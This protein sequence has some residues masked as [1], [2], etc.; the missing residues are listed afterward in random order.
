MEVVGCFLD[1]WLHM[2][3][4]KRMRDK[5]SSSQ[6]TDEPAQWIVGRNLKVFTP[7]LGLL[8]CGDDVWIMCRAGA[9]AEIW[10]CLH[11]LYAACGL[12]LNH[13]DSGSLLVN[14]YAQA[15]PAVP[16]L[17]NPPCWSL[18]ELTPAATWKVNQTRLEPRLFRAI[19]EVEDEQASIL[20][21][22]KIYNQHMDALLRQ[23]G[24]H[25]DLRQLLSPLSQVISKKFDAA[26]KPHCA[27]VWPLLWWPRSSGGL[28]AK[29]HLLFLHGRGCS[30]TTATTGS[31]IPLYRRLQNALQVTRSNCEYDAKLRKMYGDLVT[32]L[33]G[34]V[35]PVDSRYASLLT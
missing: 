2:A 20:H 15:V 8:R 21:C 9:C 12:L 32:D 26:A 7:L 22:V 4:L 1:Y 19:A 23:G 30:M 10:S 33:F 14:S 6:V 11:E 16:D 27:D 24:F 3:V 13:D 28:G 31:Q 5:H 29:Q 25:S 18:L 35:S 34:T 17:Q